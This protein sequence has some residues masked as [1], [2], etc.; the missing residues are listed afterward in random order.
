[1]KV[2]DWMT[3]DVATCVVDDSLNRAAQLMWDG[4]FGVVPVVGPEGSIVGMITDRDVCMAAYTRGR[5]LAE[6]RV[7]HAMAKHIATCSPD[8]TIDTALSLMKEA[9]VRR[10]PVVDHHGRLV[11]VLSLNDLARGARGLGGTPEGIRTRADVDET[12]AS[13]CGK[14]LRARSEDRLETP[15]SSRSKTR[16]ERPHCAV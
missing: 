7:E 13:I 2:Q 8:S 9:R 10:L 16:M 1:M 11:G 14:R 6:I 3:R 15:R 4:D 12:L 5:P